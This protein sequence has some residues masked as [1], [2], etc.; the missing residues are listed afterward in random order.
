MFT[1]YKNPLYRRFPFL[2]NKVHSTGASIIY[3]IPFVRELFMIFGHID[4]SRS[5]LKRTLNKGSSV[6]IVVGGEAEVLL[7][8]NDEDT[9]VLKERKGFVKLALQNGADLLPTYCFHNTNVFHINTS[10]L[11]GFRKWLQKNFKCS[12]PV[13]WGWRGTPLPHPVPLCLAIGDPIKVPK[14]SPGQEITDKM[15]DEYHKKYI[16][17]LTKLFEECKAAAGYPEDRML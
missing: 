7:A 13:C 4:V 8:R 14:P 12:I 17:A 3:F 11:R 6:G 10:L 5:A 16:E 15:V 9:V 2:R 1:S